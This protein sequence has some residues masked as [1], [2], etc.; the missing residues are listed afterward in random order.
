[1]PMARFHRLMEQRLLDIG[2][3]LQVNGEADLW[4]PVRQPCC[5]WTEGARPKQEYGEFMVKYNL[6][7]QVGQQP[8]DGFAVKKAFF[9]KKSGGA[10]RHHAWLAGRNSSCA[11][12]RSPRI[13]LSRCWACPAHWST[14]PRD[15]RW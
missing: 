13:Q 10:L 3:W 8:T 14:M 15:A 4:D 11:T 2:A 5:Q 7:E 12:S 9:T 1:M 6:L